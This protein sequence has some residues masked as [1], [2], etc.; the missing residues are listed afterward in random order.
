MI[1]PRRT[2]LTR[3]TALVAFPLVVPAKAV[4]SILWRRDQVVLPELSKIYISSAD[5][6]SFANYMQSPVVLWNHRTDLCPIARVNA[7]SD[8]LCDGRQS[9]TADIEFPPEGIDHYSD[10]TFALLA[11]NYVAMSFG[12]RKPNNE[13]LEISVIARNNTTGG[14]TVQIAGR[15]TVRVTFDAT[16]EDGRN[17]T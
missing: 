15:R 17:T 11:K 1:L 2:F 4:E 10:A 16:I 9:L 5:R 12:Y 6:L 14:Q 13:L 3:L 7:M 8:S